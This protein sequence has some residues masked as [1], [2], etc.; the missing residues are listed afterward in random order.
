MRRHFLSLVLLV[1]LGE[2]PLHAQQMLPDRFGGWSASSPAEKV[3]PLVPDK[4]SAEAAAI[5]REAGLVEQL[6][7]SYANQTNSLTV[8]LYKL[9]DPS[10]A[11][12]LFTYLRPQGTADSD[13]AE[14]AAIGRDRAILLE[15]NLVVDVTGLQA[16]AVSDL[17]GLASALK[18]AADQS[19]LPPIRNYLPLPA[20]IAGS[21][22]YAIGPASFRSAL[23]EF[24]SDALAPLASSLGPGGQGGE[25]MLARYRARDRVV[26]L[27]LVEFPTP[28]LAEA[29]LKK[30]ALPGAHGSAGA[31]PSGL[32]AKRKSSLLSVV[33]QPKSL[34]EA[35][36][37][38]NAVRYETQV[39]WN[40][41]S[42][43]AT[44]PTWGIII[45]GTI[46]STG[47]LMVYA[48]IGGLGFGLIRIAV[49]RF[50]PD[51]VFDR[52]AQFEILQLG[53]SSKPIQWKDLY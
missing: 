27:L 18:I 8:T 12:A 38:L 34:Q 4:P 36:A 10:G 28:Q 24:S 51:K 25:A 22:R 48:F 31:P 49:K 23:G 7:R 30:L 43:K 42:Y 46:L 44:D 29:Q 20:K 39:T 13:L 37:L 11:Y 2:L 9:R 3:A 21:E 41:A 50:F 5:L 6:N 14:Y 45:A 16:A 47:V 15:G 40:E 52:S 1:T 33:F 26:T 19:P 17:R 32:V 35:D 53:I